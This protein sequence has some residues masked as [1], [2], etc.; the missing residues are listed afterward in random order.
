MAL[1]LVLGVTGKLGPMLL[2]RDGPPPL[3][4][5]AHGAAAALIVASVVA[6]YGLGLPGGAWVR[7]FAVGAVLIPAARLWSARAAPPPR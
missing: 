5:W 7:A 1:I 6:E 4:P 2:E 3:P